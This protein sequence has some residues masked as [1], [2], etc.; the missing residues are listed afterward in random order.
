M[1]NE[2]LQAYNIN[3]AIFK[4]GRN[5]DAASPLIGGWWQLRQRKQEGWGRA[6]VLCGRQHILGRFTRV[7]HSSSARLAWAA[8]HP[9]V[10]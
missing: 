2:A 9:P 1:F 10:G 3:S 5:A 8:V 4:V 7:Q 6:R